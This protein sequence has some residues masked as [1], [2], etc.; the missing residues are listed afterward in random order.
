MF[1]CDKYLFNL[2]N[3]VYNQILSIKFVYNHN[4][5]FTDRYT[6]AEAVKILKVKT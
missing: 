3:L 5:N 2:N 1:F 6:I 4:N